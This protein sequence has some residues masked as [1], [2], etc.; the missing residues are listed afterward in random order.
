MY[1]KAYMK[2][3]LKHNKEYIYGKD[4][5]NKGKIYESEIG[6]SFIDFLANSDEIIEIIRNE[7]YSYHEQDKLKDS[8]DLHTFTRFK[9]EQISP[10]FK[11]FN[12]DDYISSYIK[13]ICDKNSIKIN[14]YLEKIK[15]AEQSLKYYRSKE[16]YNEMVEE[17]IFNY[18]NYDSKESK[19]G[20]F[21]INKAEKTTN[22]L[23][24]K[25]KDKYG[26]RF[27]HNTWKKVYSKNKNAIKGDSI[28]DEINRKIYDENEIEIKKYVDEDIK[29]RI[30]SEKDLMRFYKKHI[31]QYIKSNERTL[32]QIL[33]EYINILQ[34]WIVFSK[35]ILIN[36][37]N[38]TSN[39]YNSK[40]S[41]NQRLL[42]YLLN[43][44]RT[45]YSDK[46]FGL[47]KSEITLELE[48]DE[49]AINLSDFITKN[50]NA[51][52]HNEDNVYKK[53][54]T[55]NVN[56]TQEYSINSIE[57]FIGISL[58]QILQNDI[59]L[60]RCENCD[61]LFIST[62]K[63]N[64]K[65][66]TYEFKDKKTCRD[67]SYTIHL[68]KDE[69]SNILRKKYRTE[70]AKKNRNKHIPRIEEKFQIW[71]AKAKEQKLL[72]EKGKITVDDFNEWLTDN[73]KW[74]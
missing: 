23:M 44:E 68:Q 25:Y 60:C 50:K 65:Y 42:N 43:I 17:G 55:Y 49:D 5:L 28:I 1:E 14:N 19:K 29:S 20:F 11:F 52:L 13:D 39:K 58:I 70:N 64:E 73:S 24:K 15:K 40:L 41:S 3:N 36:F 18:H 47:P 37:Y 67:L 26:Q 33:D 22:E 27:S 51:L 30:K 7:A 54:N 69:L 66:C 74:F 34:F 63:L 38:L 9:L 61:K 62:N 53:L 16:Y 35:Y 46:I 32:E 72:C 48:N 4:F 57:D 45:Y 21:Y 71:Y 8:N 2:F 6:K 56:L 12:Y 31:K 10:L 59:K